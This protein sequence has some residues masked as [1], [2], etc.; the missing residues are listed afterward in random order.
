MNDAEYWAAVNRL[1]K[2]RTV[3]AG[4]WLGTRSKADPEAQAVRDIIE[5]YLM[6]RVEVNA[7][8][9]LLVTPPGRPGV[10]TADEFRAQI[11]CE[12]AHL[13]AALERQFP[14]FTTTDVGVEIDTRL[15][16]ET[17]KGWRP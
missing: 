4:R 15:A 14:G 12:C 13:N 7:L 5:K 9:A 6:L 11:V 10:F 8:T 17:T 16:A 2:W 1:A 3:F